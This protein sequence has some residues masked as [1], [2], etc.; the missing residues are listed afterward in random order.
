VAK[1]SPILGYNHN[2]R[3]RG[4]VFHVQTEDSGQQNPH[5]FTHLFYEGVIVSTRKYVYDAG[6][7]ED[8]LVYRVAREALR[9]V[10]SHANARSVRVEVTRPEPRMTRLVVADDGQGFSTADREARA[11]NGH[12]GLTLLDGLVR[13]SDGTLE[14]RS[15]PG[16][17]TTVELQVPVR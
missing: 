14:I 16:E 15:R 9:N 5:L 10:E 13:R 17:G 11:E 7:N 1:R 3:Y 8:A 4:L 2:V 6:S 12:I